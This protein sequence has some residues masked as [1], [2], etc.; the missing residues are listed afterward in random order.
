VKEQQERDDKK[1]QWR[2][3]NKGKKGKKGGGKG[4]GGNRP[5][6]EGRTIVS[7]KS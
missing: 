1:K 2:I 7:M 5:G 6:F 4:G 3:E